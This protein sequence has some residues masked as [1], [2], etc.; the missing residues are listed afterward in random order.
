MNWESFLAC[1]NLARESLTCEIGE[2]AEIT[3]VCLLFRL[4]CTTNV[5]RTYIQAS[6]L[7]LDLMPIKCLIKEFKINKKIA[8]HYTYT[9]LHLI[10]VTVMHAGSF[11][12]NRRRRAQ[13]GPAWR[14]FGGVE[15]NFIKIYVLICRPKNCDV[16]A[17]VKQ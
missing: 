16:R 3:L 10:K 2:R 1:S 11:F 7:G 4:Q 8:E 5:S 13:I 6:E 9:R 15:Q 12:V 17:R 14:R